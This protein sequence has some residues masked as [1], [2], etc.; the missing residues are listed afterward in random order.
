MEKLSSMAGKKRRRESLKK[1]TDYDFLV[2]LNM[3]G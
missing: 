1:I 3:R 2:F